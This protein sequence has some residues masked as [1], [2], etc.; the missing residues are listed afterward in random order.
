[1]T[2]LT[3]KATLQLQ[4]AGLRCAFTRLEDMLK[5][6]DSSFG[7]K[8][9]MPSIFSTENAFVTE[10]LTFTRVH[11]LITFELVDCYA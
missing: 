7:Y 2:A 11:E 6:T 9:E 4:G 10:A 5:I 8:S 1:M 3:E